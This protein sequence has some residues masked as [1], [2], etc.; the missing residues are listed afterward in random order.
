MSHTN[1][2]IA[3][4]QLSCVLISFNDDLTA[5]RV[6]HLSAR[7]NAQYRGPV[8]EHAVQLRLADQLGATAAMGDPKNGQCLKSKTLAR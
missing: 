6:P 7:D 3:S 4:G 1:L 8:K 2:G 5:N